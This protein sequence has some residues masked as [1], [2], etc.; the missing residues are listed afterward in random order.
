MKLLFR[1]ILLL[2]LTSAD[3]SHATPLPQN[4]VSVAVAAN[5]LIPLKALKKQFENETSYQ[6]SISS[7]STGKLYAQIMHGA[8]YHIYLAAD[9]R[10]PLL[11]EQE[12]KIIPGSRFIYAVGQLVLWT[13]QAELFDANADYETVLKDIDNFQRLSI[14]NPK[15]A[16]YGYA[17]RE[18]LE[19]QSLW[20]LLQDK[21]INGE[22]VGQAYQF[23][24]SKNAELGLLAKSQALASSDS[25]ILWSLPETLYSPIIQQAVLLKQAKNR[26]AAKAFAEFLQSPTA[27]KIIQQQGYAVTNTGIDVE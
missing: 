21:I 15:T 10:R 6:L 1:L 4:T 5:F 19:Q 3:I 25:G 16:P 2:L 7:G 23:V 27:R 13:S 22:N 17:A 14:A 24:A 20:I 18:L 11:L 8:P 26:I 12:N 9:S